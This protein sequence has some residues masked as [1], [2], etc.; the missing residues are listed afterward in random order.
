M[1][2]IPH[3]HDRLAE[4]IRTGDIETALD[5]QRA[6]TEASPPLP[7]LLD[8]FRTA[9]ERGDDA[10]AETLLRRIEGRIQE[11]RPEERSSVEQA[12][13]T[14]EEDDPDRE[15]LAALQAHI[16]NATETSLDR[17]G[18]L[19]AATTYLEDR[20]ADTGDVT[21]AADTLQGKERDLQ[22]SAESVAETLESTTL[23]ASVEVVAIDGAATERA[24]DEEFAV[25]ATVENVGDRR[26]GDVTV[27]VEAEDG[28]VASPDRRGPV[29]VEPGQRR[30]VEFTVLATRP[31]EYSLDFRVDSES[32]GVSSGETT[33]VVREEAGEPATPVEA[34]A[35]PEGEVTFDGV[36][37][38]ISLYNQDEP[39]PETD[40]MT[41]DFADVVGVI[42]AYNRRG[43]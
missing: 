22:S 30:D 34:I 8:E 37:T 33:V 11:R 38:A 35:G 25:A 20:S 32:G 24:V 7:E 6:I 16:E 21:D 36:V 14:R 1:T 5:A 41:L 19:G 29:P 4:A 17:A 18:F 13:L 28:L 3:H 39:V 23:P 40:G 12:A 42:A 43:S 15:T 10:Q 2:D 27:T 9:V 26:A 31:G